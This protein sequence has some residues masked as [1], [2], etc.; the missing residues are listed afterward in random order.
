MLPKIDAVGDSILVAGSLQ[1]AGAQRGDS[2]KFS[3]VVRFLHQQLDY[4]GGPPCP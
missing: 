3:I 1:L 4:E 2:K